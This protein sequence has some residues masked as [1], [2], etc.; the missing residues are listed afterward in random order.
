MHHAFTLTPTLSNIASMKSVWHK[1]SPH[2]QNQR[3]KQPKPR[4]QPFPKLQV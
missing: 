1:P 2:T 4:K 3:E